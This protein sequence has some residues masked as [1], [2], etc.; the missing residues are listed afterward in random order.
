MNSRCKG[1]VVEELIE[2]CLVG[3]GTVSGG[4]LGKLRPSCVGSHRGSTLVLGSVEAA[5]GV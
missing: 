5:G 4:K 2:S 3:V 1:P